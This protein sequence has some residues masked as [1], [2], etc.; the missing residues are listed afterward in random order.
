ML[1]KLAKAILLA[2][3]LAGMALTALILYFIFAGSGL[4]LFPEGRDVENFGG[5]YMDVARAFDMAEG[6]GRENFESVEY[7]FE[8]ARAFNGDGWTTY[9]IKLKGVDV[10][11]LDKS[12]WIPSAEVCGLLKAAVDNFKSEIKNPEDGYF[13]APCAIRSYDGE[14]PPDDATILVYTP[15]DSRLY[16]FNMNL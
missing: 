4:S 8:S 5:S 15:S 16:Y 7:L 14:G 3:G 12:F 11:A 1:L 2:S 9:I 6:I 13:V 10:G